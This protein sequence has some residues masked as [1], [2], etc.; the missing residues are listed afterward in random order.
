MATTTLA[1]DSLAILRESYAL[2]LAATRAEKTSTIYLAAFDRFLDY[3]GA[4]GMPTSV[5]GVKREHI[6]AFVAE[7]RSRV[8]P[9]TVSVEFRALQQFWKWA[10][11]EDEIDRSPMDKL[12]PPPLPEVPVPVVSEDAFRRLLRTAEGKEFVDRRD[13]AILLFMYDTGVR[14]GEVA[15]LELDHVDLR[16]REAYVTG[17]GARSRVVKF[18]MKTAVALD[19]YLRLRRGHRHAG[20]PA[21]WLGQDGPLTASAFGQMVAKRAIA[22]GLG[23]IHPHQLRHTFA[24]QHLAAG[25]TEGD[26][27]RLAGWKS[28]SMVDRYAASRAAER[29]REAYKSPADRL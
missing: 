17:K 11:R 29:A 13:T 6:E 25:G 19:R 23:R 12:T 15:G 22:A 5:R 26:L 3:L 28:R 7:R 1:P 14:R 27:M 24:D 2:H 8:K 20:K 21:F 16:E 4:Q 10:E 18:G 9:A